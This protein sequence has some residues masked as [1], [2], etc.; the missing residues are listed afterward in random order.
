V[1]SF[2]FNYEPLTLTLSPSDGER[3]T[4]VNGIIPQEPG[5]QSVDK[6]VES[7]AAFPAQEGKIMDCA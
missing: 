3:E 5:F 4:S 7:K 6:F 2:D 1:R